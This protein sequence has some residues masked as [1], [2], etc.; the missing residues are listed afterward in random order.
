MGSRGSHAVVVG[1]S[2]GGLL[3]ARALSGPYHK[4][5]VLDRDAL[6]DDATPRRGVPQGRQLHFLL[7]RGAVILDAMFPGILDELEAAGVPVMRHFQEGSL[8]FGGRQFLMPDKPGDPPIYNPT[9]PFLEARVRARV[10]ALPGVAVIAGREVSG[11]L[12]TTDRARVTGVRVR[13]GRDG[14]EHDLTADLV[15]DATGRGGRSPV[16]LGE[17]GYAPAPEEKLA[18]DLVYATRLIRLPAGALGRRQLIAVGAVPGRPRSVAACAVEGDRWILTPAGYAGHH[19][20]ADDAGFDAYVR[21]VVPPATAEVLL[22]G[23]R[24][25]DVVTHRFP[26]NLRRRYE[27]LDRFPAGYL[28]IGDAVCSFNPLYAQGMTVAAM[29]AEA[30]RACLVRGKGSER[31]LAKRFFRAAAGAVDVGWDFAT[32]ADLALPEVA[33]PRSVKVRAGIAYTAQVQ[34]AATVDPE[35]SEVFGRVLAFVDPPTALLAPAFVNRVVR[36]A[37]KAGPPDPVWPAGA[38]APRAAAGPDGPSAP[39]RDLAD[40][41]SAPPPAPARAD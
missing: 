24:L 6:P 41:S 35:V 13:L 31:G 4:V 7:S 38:P 10:A 30:L 14:S 11:L 9:R 8:N 26:A 1:A 18:V 12:H 39:A 19:P 16:W 20:P 32:G 37:R 34:A 25:G 28:V 21:S 5:T 29:E 15:V 36:G 22:A 27:K 17:L 23:E 2:M 40:G 3:A 33:G